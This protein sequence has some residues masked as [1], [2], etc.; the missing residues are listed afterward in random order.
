LGEKKFKRERE[1]GKC[2]KMNKI[3]NLRKRESKYLR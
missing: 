2:E 1:K 3:K